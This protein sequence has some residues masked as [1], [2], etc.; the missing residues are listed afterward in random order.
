M[1]RDIIKIDD[2]SY[3]NLSY[4]TNKTKLY[5]LFYQV[6]NE[7]VTQLDTNELGIFSIGY[8]KNQLIKVLI[9]GFYYLVVCTGTKLY[10][11]S[12]SQIDFEDINL[13]KN[14]WDTLKKYLDLFKSI[15]KIVYKFLKFAKNRL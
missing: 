12:S 2:V 7:F 6:Y 8:F 11:S 3:L 4:T 15:K 10:K 9:Y 5:D 13:L 1:K 14:S